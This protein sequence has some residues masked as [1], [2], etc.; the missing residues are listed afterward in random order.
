MRLQTTFAA[1]GLVV[2]ACGVG[3]GAGVTTTTPIAETTTTTE[4][5]TTTLV[6]ATTTT[7]PA[8]TTT[9]PA[10]TTTVAGT[11]ATTLRGDPVD[12]GPP[13]GAVLGVIGVEHDDVLNLRAR[14]GADQPIIGRIPPTFDNLIALGN[15]RHLPS[16]FWTNVRYKGTEGWVNM[17]YVAYLGSI[18]DTTAQVIDHFGER[19]EASTMAEL[20]RMIAEAFAS[21]D[22]P[23]DIVN[24]VEETGGDL[25]EV[26]FDVVGLGDDAVRGL[27]LHIFAENLDGHFQ[28]R[29][30][31]QTTFCDPARGVDEGSCV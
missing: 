22:P 3:A 16:S 6:P 2:A 10:T 20:G 1:L 31:E 4:A 29:T 15:T 13:S 11:S 23:S 17:R 28:L 25:G 7:A 19:P 24:S 27:R 8:T 26:T 18:D 5:P 21:E 30:V 12:M 9:A 14:P